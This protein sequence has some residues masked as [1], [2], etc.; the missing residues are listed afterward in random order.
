MTAT[1]PPVETVPFPVAVV[2]D[3]PKLRTRLVMQL[4]ETARATSHASLAEAEEDG[5][6]VLVVGPS[7]SEGQ[8]LNDV[9]ALLRARPDVSAVMVVDELSTELLQRAIRAGVNDVITVPS[10]LAEAVDRAVENLNLLPPAPAGSPAMGDGE[11]ARVITVFSTKGGSGKSVIA[12]NLACELAGR[13]E[14]PVVLLD[15]DLQFGDVA[16]MLKLA[17]Q[18]TIVDAVSAL[19][20]LDAQLL[21]SLLVTHERSGLLILAAP[22]EPAFADQVSP[23]AMVKILE[24]LRTFCS[25][26]VIDTPSHFTDVVLSILEDSDDIVLV[27]GMDIPN[28]KNVK[29]G[30]QT[31]RL[32]DMSSSKLKLVLNRA[33]AKVK[34]DVSEVERTLQLKADCLVPSDVV[35]P[36]SVN[37]GIPAI[38]DAP[39]SGV[40]RSMEQLADLF[41]S[42]ARTKR[43]GR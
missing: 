12:A 43:R 7:F 42:V 5:P 2:D 10:E 39:K 11:Q 6:M 18:N 23:A 8:G 30:L 37:K 24:I 41:T 16:V 33:N 27:A 21:R 29:I 9:A 22:T 26:V 34:L 32:L 14:K 15:A 17:P 13:S 20:R 35:V 1:L 25:Y 4:G 19:H 38:Y 40:A 28:I 36:R 31:L 3:D